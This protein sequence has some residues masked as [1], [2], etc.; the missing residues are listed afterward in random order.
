[1]ARLPTLIVGVPTTNAALYRRIRFS[2][3]DP[4][5]IIDWPDDTSTL[6]LRA[7][8]MDRARRHARADIVRCPEDFTP[9]A[10]LSGD[11]ETATAQSV[12]ECLRRSGTLGVIA[13]RSTPLVFSHCLREAGIEVIYDP[14]LGAAAQR[15]K[16]AQELAWLREAQRVTEDAVRLACALVAGAEAGTSGELIVD[17]APLTSERVRQ[18]VDVFLLERGYVNPASIVAGGPQ[19]ADCHNLG[20][21]ALFTGQ[22]VIIDTFPRN[23]DTRYNGDCTRTVVHGDVPDEVA[24]MHATVL[25]AKAAASNATRAGATGHDVHRATIEVITRAGYHMGLP[26]ADAPDTYTSMPHATGHGIGLE[27][28]EPPL[29]DINGPTL[30]VNDVLT[31]EP[32][33]YCKALGGVRVEDMVIVNEDGCENCTTLPEGLNWS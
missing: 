17:D 13:H 21:G 22:P 20:A 18:A 29:L 19:G 11:R 1:M 9:E 10:G 28:H 4:A 7:I 27:G 33:L 5:A 2:A 12:A 6:I 24:R 31:I 26:P 8:E 14:D 16:D 30:V 23:R 25:E 3:G 15:S 32:G